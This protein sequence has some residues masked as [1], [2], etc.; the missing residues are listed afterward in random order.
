MII[1]DEKVFA[2]AGDVNVS[3]YRFKM[4]AFLHYRLKLN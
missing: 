4:D 2:E 3:L 1:N